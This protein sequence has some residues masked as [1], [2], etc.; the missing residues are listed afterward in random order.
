VNSERVFEWQ[1]GSWLGWP[2]ELCWALLAAVSVGGVGLMAWRQRM[3]FVTLRSGFFL[4][5]LFCLAGPL[6]GGADL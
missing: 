5:L 1:L 3:L 4:S 2:P 6:P